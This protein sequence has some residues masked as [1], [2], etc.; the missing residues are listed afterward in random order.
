MNWVSVR[1]CDPRLDGGA[2]DNLSAFPGVFKVL[3]LEKITGHK[4][5]FGS[6]TVKQETDLN[7]RK[8]GGAGDG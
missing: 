5:V 4:D 8:R 6:L 7:A 2:P 1:S 3:S